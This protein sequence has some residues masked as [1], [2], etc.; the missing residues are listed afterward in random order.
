MLLTHSCQSRAFRFRALRVASK[1]WRGFS[2]RHCH[3]RTYCSSTG[4]GLFRLTERKPL[5]TQDLI[6]CHAAC[7]YGLGMDALVIG[8][9]ENANVSMVLGMHALVIGCTRNTNV[10]MI[11]AWMLWLSDALGTLTLL[12][13]GQKVSRALNVLWANSTLPSP[14][15]PH[16]PRQ[17]S[18]TNPKTG[19]GN[20]PACKNNE[21]RIRA[22]R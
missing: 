16:P 5:G 6:C 20:P 18:Q 21:S 9:T 4:F 2:N 7:D 3:C 10:I 22:S 11:W 15:P 12:W 19:Y 1:S 8:C 13:F 14:S 17:S